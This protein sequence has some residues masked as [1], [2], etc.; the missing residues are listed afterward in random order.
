MSYLEQ[1]KDTNNFLEVLVQDH[2]R[3]MP[4]MEFLDN[5]TQQKSELT[6][7]EREMISLEVSKANGAEFCIGIHSGMLRAMGSADNKV[8]E[9]KIKPVLAFANKLAKNSNQVS[10]EDI[11]ILRKAGWND[12]TIEDIIGLVSAIS[13]YDI[14]SNG[15]GFKASLP[16]EVFEQM[17]QGTLEAGGFVAQF[18]SF[19]Q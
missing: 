10:P 1:T 14:L 18:K 16:Q 4:I 12:Q 9:E 3:Y 15:F 8:A 6:W 2:K 13:I 17:G 7:E 11:K 19:I 5:L